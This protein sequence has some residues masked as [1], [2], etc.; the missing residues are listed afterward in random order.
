MH[1]NYIDIQISDLK[2]TTPVVLLS[3]Q[4][5]RRVEKYTFKNKHLT[6]E[7]FLAHRSTLWEP[8]LFDNS[9]FFSYDGLEKKSSIDNWNTGFHLSWNSHKSSWPIGQHV[10]CNLAVLVSS[11]ALITSSICSSVVPSSNPV[12]MF[13]YR[14]LVAFYHLGG[15]N[16]FVLHFRVT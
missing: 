5:G 6:S 11:P 12:M 8:D 9:G 4:G 2:I 1:S 13:V 16:P 10:T 3:E 15:F 14:L 7:I